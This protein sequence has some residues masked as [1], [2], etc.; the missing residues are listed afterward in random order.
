MGVILSSL[1]KLIVPYAQLLS[2]LT[3]NL[4]AALYQTLA[5]PW[6]HSTYWSCLILAGR[7]SVLATK[8]RGT[9]NNGSV[10]GPGPPPWTPGCLP[11][12]PPPPLT[13]PVSGIINATL[14][15]TIHKGPLW[16][17][18][19]N[20]RCERRPKEREGVCVCGGWVQHDVLYST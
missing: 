14:T 1:F 15:T 6:G 20:R 19:I 3:F 13:A 10:A 16:Q 11:P 7:V 18:T 2:D 17:E 9:M 8:P 5:R 4:A 12:A